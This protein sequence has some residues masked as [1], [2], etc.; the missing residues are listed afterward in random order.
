MKDAER[1]LRT[2][3][4]QIVMCAARFIEEVLH[5]MPVLHHAMVAHHENML[6]AL[7][8]IADAEGNETL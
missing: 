1:K 4:Q 8:R 6:T 3:E 2:E 5:S 7:Y